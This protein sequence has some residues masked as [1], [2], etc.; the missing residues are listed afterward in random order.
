MGDY[1]GAARVG[2][3]VA[4]PARADGPTPAAAF[5]APPPPEPV[6]PPGVLPARVEAWLDHDTAGPLNVQIVDTGW[7]LGLQLRAAPAAAARLAPAE[8]D[9]RDIL[10][11]HRRPPGGERPR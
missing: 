2:G 5:P 1:V 7:T 10:N 3:A 8:Q 6:R 11:R 4:V 9:L